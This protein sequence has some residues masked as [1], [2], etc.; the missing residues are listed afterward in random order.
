MLPRA[1]RLTSSA[2]IAAVIKNGHGRR[3]PHATVYMWIKPDGCAPQ[4]AIAV[5]KT[6]GNSVVRSA[7]SR[8]I[9]HGLAPLIPM[10]PAGAQVV[11]RAFDSAATPSS[12]DWTGNLRQ[13]LAPWLN[14]AAAANRGASDALGMPMSAPAV[15]APRNAHE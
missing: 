6:V 8:R 9:R 5:G 12:T 2:D 1:H 15:D 4:A 11:V 7:V 14:Q 13:A 3:L 10:L